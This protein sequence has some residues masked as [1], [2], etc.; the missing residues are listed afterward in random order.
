M[1]K[2][3]LLDTLKQVAPCVVISVAR[4]VDDFPPKWDGE[5]IDPCERGYW[6]YIVTVTAQAIQNGELVEASDTLGGCYYRKPTARKS[7]EPI[8]DV[9]GYLPDMCYTALTSLMNKISDP[10]VVQLCRNA[11]LTCL[12]AE[13]NNL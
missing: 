7:A 9:H 8:G 4:R 13:L 11:R 5:G 6:P 1:K 3:S 10:K 12:A 2:S